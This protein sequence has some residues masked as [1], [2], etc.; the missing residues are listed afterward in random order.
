MAVRDANDPDPDRRYKAALLN[1][2]F[3]VSPDGVNWTK[4]DVPADT[5]LRRRKLLLQ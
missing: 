4:L 5:K 2:G 3:A 1:A